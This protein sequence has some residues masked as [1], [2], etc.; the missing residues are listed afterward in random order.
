M[1][2]CYPC[3]LFVCACAQMDLNVCIVR[4]G[5]WALPR[6]ASPTHHASNKF[7]KVDHAIPPH[8]IMFW[9]A[10]MMLLR[11]PRHGRRI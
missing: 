9:R 11:V 3:A 6:R 4:L 2:P 8:L 5:A 1:M 10:M 7:K